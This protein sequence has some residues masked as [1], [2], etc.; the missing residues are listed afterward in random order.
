MKYVCMKPISFAGIEY[1]PGDV[2]PDGIVLDS[3]AGKLK[4]SGYIADVETTSENPE[5]PKFH[6]GMEIRY[7]QEEL[8]AAVAEAVDDAVNKTVAEMQQKQAEL[9]EYVAE[10]Q[11]ISPDMY[12][13]AFMV[14]VRAEESEG[15]NAQYISLPMTP[16]GVAQVV[17]IMQSKTN[18]GIEAIS[19]ITDENVLILIHALDSRKTVKNAAKKQAGTLTNPETEKDD[20]RD[21]IESTGPSTSN[22]NTKEDVAV[23]QDGEDK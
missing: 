19:D 5:P 12:T 21:S 6:E 13:G 18:E 17:S 15:E 2:I 20:V 4:G 7:T 10:L 14:P 16:E 11:Q 9:Q 23:P 8:D 1:H 22:A 3:R